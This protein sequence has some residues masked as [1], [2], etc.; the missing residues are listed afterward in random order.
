[1][2]SFY[3]F[4]LAAALLTSANGE[5]GHLPWSSRART[6]FKS[7]EVAKV[8]LASRPETQRV[9]PRVGR[10]RCCRANPLKPNG[11]ATQTR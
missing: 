6:C 3:F 7:P 11:G 5:L 2:S 10:A 9:K 8:S 4:K 1:M